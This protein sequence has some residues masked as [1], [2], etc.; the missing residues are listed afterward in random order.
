[1]YASPVIYPLKLVK[2]KLLVNQAAGDWSHALYT[3]YTLNPLAGIIDAFQSVVLR[4]EAPDL[5]AMVPGAILIAVLLPLSYRFFK[6]A[7]AW[8]ADVI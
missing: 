3:L 7:E 1:M 5:T 8:F 6:H 4:G 2:D